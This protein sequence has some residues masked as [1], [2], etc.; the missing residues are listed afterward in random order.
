MQ[1]HTAPFHSPQA[2]ASSRA[3]AQNWQPH[4]L[5]GCS[6]RQAAPL[7][8]MHNILLPFTV[9]KPRTAPLA[10]LNATS[11]ALPHHHTI[12]NTPLPFTVLRHQRHFPQV[13]LQG[14]TAQ[15]GPLHTTTTC[16]NAEHT[17][18]FHSL[19]TSTSFPADVLAGRNGASRALAQ[20][21]TMKT[22]RR[23][24]RSLHSPRAPASNN[25]I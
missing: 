24:H 6:Q 4:R 19:Q 5:Q 9:L 20:Q 23:K 10:R 12:H 1:R 7:H 15:A 18:T 11:R 3:L 25:Y 22:C 14:V 13:C 2:S 8:T 16:R 21:N 17:A